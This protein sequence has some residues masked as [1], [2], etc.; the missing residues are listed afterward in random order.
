MLFLCAQF[1][2]LLLP[3]FSRE[4]PSPSP[5][6][7]GFSGIAPTSDNRI[8]Y[9][10]WAWQVRGLHPSDIV[11]GTEIRQETMRSDSDGSSQAP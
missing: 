6:T 8:G 5:Q 1:P 4:A 2:F 11:A 10:S 3:D 9:E 7:W